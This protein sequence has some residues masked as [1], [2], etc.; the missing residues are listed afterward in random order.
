[1]T[2]YFG[3]SMQKWFRLK[4]VSCSA[5]PAKFSFKVITTITNLL[6]NL[7][8]YFWEHGIYEIRISRIFPN[9]STNIFSVDMK[10]AQFSHILIYRNRFCGIL[11]KNGPW[12]NLH[13]INL[14]SLLGKGK[15]SS[16]LTKVLGADITFFGARGKRMGEDKC[17]PFESDSFTAKC[18]S[19][20]I[21]LL[22]S[23]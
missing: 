17:F 15:R 20:G 3:I 18:L 22:R 4:F 10:R 14:S 2:K 16:L 1:M 21:V 9:E 6:L 7:R 19:Y 13:A 11:Y 8:S 23:L 5:L 12:K